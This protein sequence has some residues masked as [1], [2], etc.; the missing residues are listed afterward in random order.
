MSTKKNKNTH[1]TKRDLKRKNAEATTDEDAPIAVQVVHCQHCASFRDTR[2]DFT[3]YSVTTVPKSAI[4]NDFLPSVK[5][6]DADG[7]AICEGCESYSWDRGMKTQDS[8]DAETARMLCELP[9]LPRA[10]VVGA[11]YISSCN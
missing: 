11:I 9:S 4:P 3:S 7:L 1:T 6:I 8:P 10:T 2:L 5:P